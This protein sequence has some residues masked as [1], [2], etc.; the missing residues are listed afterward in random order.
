VT[1]TPLPMVFFFFNYLLALNELAAVR[2]SSVVVSA[3]PASVALF[4]P[5]AVST[6]I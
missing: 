6:C 5:A 1:A 4:E 3:D 2:T